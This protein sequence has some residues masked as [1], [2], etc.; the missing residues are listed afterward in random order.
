MAKI[1]IEVWENEYSLYDYSLKYDDEV[2]DISD[3]G[4]YR[5][6]EGALAAAHSLAQ[7]HRL[8]L[9]DNSKPKH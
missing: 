2:I 6:E 5:F 1:E 8:K 3:D 7:K 9:N 4:N